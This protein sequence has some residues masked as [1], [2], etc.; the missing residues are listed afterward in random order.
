MALFGKGNASFG[1]NT[2]FASNVTGFGQFYKFQNTKYTW[3]FEDIG[4]SI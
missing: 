3:T 1:K 2:K 4:R